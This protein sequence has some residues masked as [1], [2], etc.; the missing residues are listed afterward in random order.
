[1]KYATFRSILIKF[2]FIIFIIQTSNRFK[3]IN[4]N[5]FVLFTFALFR[6]LLIFDND[7]S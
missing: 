5:N 6:D 2:D 7:S 1:M 4:E 3:L